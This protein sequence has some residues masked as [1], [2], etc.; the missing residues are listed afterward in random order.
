MKTFNILSALLLTFGLFINNAMASKVD[1][2]KPLFSYKEAKALNYEEAMKMVEYPAV[3]KNLAIEG[4]V[5]V[6]VYVDAD[7]TVQKYTVMEGSD[8]R[9]ASAVESAVMSLEFEPTIVINNTTG[10]AEAVPSWVV[11]PFN[12]S[13]NF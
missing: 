3:G 2:D 11:I 6:R 5:K 7:G 8:H 1:D 12:F 9:L 4:T 13:L 10:D